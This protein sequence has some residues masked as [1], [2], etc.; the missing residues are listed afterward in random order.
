MKGVILDAASLGEG[1]SLSGLGKHI[2]SIEYY[3][4]TRPEEVVSRIQGKQI[5]IVNKVV[6]GEA[7]LAQA[8]DLKLIAVTATG[9]N[10]I[11]LDAAKK[12]DI[13]VVNVTGYGRATVVQHTF[14]LILAL[15]NN[16]INYV[17]DVRSGLW[18]KSKTFCLMDHPIRELEGKTLGVIGYGELGQGVAKMGEAFGMNVLVGAR[19]GASR[20]SGTENKAEQKGRVDRVSLETLI[21][22]SDVI[23][24]HCLLSAETQ[25]LI[26]SRELEMMKPGAILINTSRGGLID[27]TALADALRERRIAGAA[28]DVLSEEPPVNGNPLLAEDIPNL[29][30]TPHCAW[31]SREARQRLIDITAE[32][33]S[34]FVANTQERFIV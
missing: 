33:I 29:I 15:S 34:R 4:G 10:N 24:L 13:R 21:Q 3:D 16:L 12:H 27:E 30:V 19:Q 7:E 25:G 32:N 18:A 6:L 23:S 9:T 11:D 5:V 31:A 26:G 1:V 14:S 22:T 8:P 28:T 17:A 2:E 20:D